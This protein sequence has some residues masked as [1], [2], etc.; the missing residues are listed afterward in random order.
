MKKLPLALL[1]E[2]KLYAQSPAWSAKSNAPAAASSAIWSRPKPSLT[3]KSAHTATRWGMP[4][5]GAA[6]ATKVVGADAT[7][8]SPHAYAYVAPGT[9]PVSSAC[10]MLPIVGAAA[11][12][13]AARRVSAPAEAP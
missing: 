7:A 12:V 8:P 10:E 3:P 13:A 9:R 5:A 2:S 11:V 6:P 1:P 4:G